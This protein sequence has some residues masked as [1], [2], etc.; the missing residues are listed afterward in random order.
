MIHIALG[1]NMKVETGRNNSNDGSIAVITWRTQTKTEKANR[2]QELRRPTW[3][4]N[5]NIE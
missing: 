5:V 1:G 4:A 2:M 3:R